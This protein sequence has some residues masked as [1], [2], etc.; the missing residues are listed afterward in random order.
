MK[1]ILKGYLKTDKL[2]RFSYFNEMKKTLL[3]IVPFGYGEITLKDFESFLNGCILMK[4][5]MNHMET[6]PNF[7]IPEQTFISFPWNFDGLQEK[8]EEVRINPKNICI[9]LKEDKI[10]IKNILFI[11]MQQNYFLSNL[12]S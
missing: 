10:S 9:F 6:W 5:R 11:G 1:K 3:S 7:Y 8:I 12:V 4:P 2:N